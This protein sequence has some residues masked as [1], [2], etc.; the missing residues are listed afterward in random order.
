MMCPACGEKPLRIGHVMCY[1]CWTLVPIDLQSTVWA[2]WAR[3]QEDPGD[4]SAV[5]E[6][7]RA[8][9]AAIQASIA[10]RNR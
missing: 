6:H 4:D 9:D 5:E 2:T 7:E 10:R 8:K 1:R 3:R